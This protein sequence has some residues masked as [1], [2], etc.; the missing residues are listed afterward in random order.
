MLIAGPEKSAPV[1]L[2]A[3]S[4][5]VGSADGSVDGLAVGSAVSETM[6]G[7]VWQRVCAWVDL[8]L[9]LP[10]LIFVVQLTVYHWWLVQQGWTTFDH[11]LYSRE[12]EIKKI[13]LKV[14]S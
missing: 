13:E 1:T 4:S 7:Q 8:G 6:D 5:G 10:T 12:L 11:I 2:D 14:S 3:P 9:T